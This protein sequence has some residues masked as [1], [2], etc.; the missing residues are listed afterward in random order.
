MFSRGRMVPDSSRM[1]RERE[2]EER[3][4]AS[5]DEIIRRRRYEEELKSSKASVKATAVMVPSSTETVKNKEEEPIASAPPQ[6]EQQQQQAVEQRMY[7]PQP[8]YYSAPCPMPPP[9]CPLPNNPPSN[10]PPSKCPVSSPVYQ[11]SPPPSCQVPPP[12]HSVPHPNYVVQ[13]IVYSVPAYPAPS[14][15][16]D[17]P[18][19]SFCSDDR[20]GVVLFILVV[21]ALIAISVAVLLGYWSGE[22]VTID[23][24]TP[25][26]DCLTLDFGLATL[27]VVSIVA[28][29]VTLIGIW[30]LAFATWAISILN[31]G[32]LVLCLLGC[33]LYSWIYCAWFLFW[34]LLTLLVVCFLFFIGRWEERCSFTAYLKQASRALLGRPKILAEALWRALL[35][36]FLLAYIGFLALRI[37][38]L[39]QDW[40]MRGALLAFLAFA[41]LLLTSM[42][43]GGGESRQAAMLRSVYASDAC[44]QS[45]VPLGSLV[46]GA[47]NATAINLLYW[48]NT[49][50][51]PCAAG[52]TYV[53][54]T[55]ATIFF[56][57]N[58]LAS[59]YVFFFLGIN[60]C[61][62]QEASKVI[63]CFLV[64]LGIVP[65]GGRSVD[66]QFGSLLHD[67]C[68]HLHNLRCLGCHH[69]I[70][71]GLSL[72]TNSL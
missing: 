42:I 40:C 11:Q 53:L 49:S 59:R 34:G 38:H 68:R 67:R 22:P 33:L 63:F 12:S 18:S 5:S 71:P 17:P 39:P 35:K 21:G 6:Q 9:N 58:R 30:L 47:L 2:E 55:L 46:Y 60:A 27:L 44:E 14:H 26:Y 41:S 72:A 45:S 10:C 13:P 3:A 69:R 66:N 43:S 19:S 28:H 62:F 61:S 24:Q 8:V 36:Y 7:D 25:F 20:G 54:N 65:D 48:T 4:R 64:C 51:L 57:A 56:R 31:F 15:V 50:P 29:T 1:A 16:Q 52:S 32:I 70:P 37:S 23:W